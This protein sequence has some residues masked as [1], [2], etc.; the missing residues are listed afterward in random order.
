MQKILISTIVRNRAKFL[1]LWKS[2]IDSLINLNPDI[3]FAL[4][5]YEND[6]ID[7]T[8]NILQSFS[9]PEYVLT[10]EDI[11]TPYFGSVVSDDR[12]KFMANARN[13]TFDQYPL[14]TVDKILI[15]EVD[16][17]YNPADIRPLLVSDYDIYSGISTHDGLGIWDAWS[18]RLD[19]NEE[20]WQQER[21]LSGVIPMYAVGNGLTVLNAE[22]FKRGVRYSGFNDRL[23]KG[24][25]D[26]SVICE[27]FHSLGFS[28]VAMNCEI[29]VKHIG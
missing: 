20:W 18:S 8:K 27:K 12:V 22:P 5:V 3:T 23:G 7:N 21:P 29:K 24:D 2:Q 16:Y 13:K 25:C 1:P 6:S 11:G 15:I 9:F 17:L 26:T 28:K 19:A 4:S 14:D 10:C